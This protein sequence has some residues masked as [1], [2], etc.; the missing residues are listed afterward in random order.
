MKKIQNYV[1]LIMILALCL[2]QSDL[3]SQ[4]TKTFNYQAVIR[5]AN[6]ELLQNQN[7]QILTSNQF[8]QLQSLNQSI[9]PY[10]LQKIPIRRV[11][12][13]HISLL[14]LACSSICLRYRTIPESRWL[15]R[16]S[17]AAV[18]FCH[19]SSSSSLAAF[20]RNS[21]AAHSYTSKSFS[22]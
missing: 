1:V 22:M 20:S 9:C 5:D 2:N 12:Y 11:P 13:H 17:L 4:D 18:T 8:H 10:R 3:Y 19:F 21:G 16:G 7:I 15:A 6:S 14:F